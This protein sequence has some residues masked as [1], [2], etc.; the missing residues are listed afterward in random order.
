MNATVALW[1]SIVIG[2]CA[3]ILLKRGISNSTTQTTAARP[4]WW[5]SLLR[6][7]WVWAWAVSFVAATGLW[8]IA[9]SR[10]NISLAFPLLSA[11][12]VLVALLS[13]L[14]LKETIRWRRWAAIG[15]I[16]LGVVLI[17]WK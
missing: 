9:V 6:S 10:I 11:S 1:T 2:A 16:C 4:G 17:A 8:L 5:L 3:Q 13:Q 7:G 14:V 15:V 12:Y